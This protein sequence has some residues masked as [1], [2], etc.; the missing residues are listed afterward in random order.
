MATMKKT[1]LFIGLFALLIP[2]SYSDGGCIKVAD[3]VLVQLSS[4]PVVPRAHQQVSYLFSFGNQQGLINREINGTLK[5]VKS[6]ETVFTKSFKIK[7]G[8]LEL[9]HTYEEPGS[10]EIYFDFQ[11]GNKNY[12]PEDFLVEVIEQKNGFANK[13]IFLVIGTIIGIVSANF[14]IKKGKFNKSRQ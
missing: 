3:D 9:K 1:L 5:I 12:K 10:Y 7:D 11:I 2:I 13:I 6:D 4:A 14:V 8:I